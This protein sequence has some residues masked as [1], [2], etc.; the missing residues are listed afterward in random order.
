M[1]MDISLLKVHFYS[2]KG[3]TDK[4]KAFFLTYSKFV[5][6]RLSVL[7]LIMR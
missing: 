1:D 2:R 6:E 3:K 4:I 7:T 5:F